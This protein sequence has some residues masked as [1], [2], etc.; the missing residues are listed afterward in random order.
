MKNEIEIL[1]P[2]YNSINYGTRI[3]VQYVI[4]NIDLNFSS[5]LFYVNDELV[6]TETKTKSIFSIS[7]INGVNIIKAYCI[8]KNNKKIIDTEIEYRF[9]CFAENIKK[10]ISLNNIISLQL[11]EFIRTDYPQF[12]EFIKSYYKFL[13][14]SNDPNKIIYNL[15]NYKNIDDIPDFILDKIKQEVMVDFNLQ[16]T[17]DIQTQQPINHKNVIK[18]IK[19]FYDSKGTP[20]SIKFLFRILF[21]KEITIEYPRI[22]ILKPSASLYERKKY[23][24][25]ILL[26]L[27]DTE[28]IKGK[29]LYQTKTDGKYQITANIA[30]IVVNV[31][32]GNYIAELELNQIKGTFDTNL[33]IYVKIIVDGAEE[34]VKINPVSYTL[35]QTSVSKTDTSYLSGSKVIQDSN[36]YQDFS[37]VIKSDIP[38]KK[39]LT[40]IKKTAHPA[41]FKVFGSF[42]SNN[43]IN[44]NSVKTRESS[45]VRFSVPL[46]GNYL[47][48]VISSPLDLTNFPVD[49]G[50]IDSNNDPIITYQNIYSFGYYAGIQGTTK[51]TDTDYGEYI[52]AINNA[53]VSPELSVSQIT[54]DEAPPGVCETCIDPNITSLNSHLATSLSESIFLPTDQIQ[55]A[56]NY[57]PVGKH[58]N[59]IYSD[60]KKE[61]TTDFGTDSILNL[62]TFLDFTIKDILNYQTTNTI[63]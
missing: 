13:E 49:T 55:N 52:S 27:D 9:N 60:N 61:D 54:I 2:T 43:K 3:N 29:T 44:F 38:P 47:P 8:N 51:P 41:G 11:P 14:Q 32:E 36:Y 56:G 4:K 18:H 17:K 20:N 33:N 22:H 12:I 48:Y 53:A 15:E 45:I 58:W 6:L 24:S 34:F 46:I 63:Q 31:V 5:V 7:P 26:S 50:T 39:Y 37:Y 35:L 30:N 1:T 59:Q 21:D 16:L 40:T 19:E 42:S 23:L 28:K 10:E 57:W 25:I 62:K